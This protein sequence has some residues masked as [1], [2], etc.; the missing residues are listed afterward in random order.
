MANTPQQT[1]GIAQEFSYAYQGAGGQWVMTKEEFEGHKGFPVVRNGSIGTFWEIPLLIDETTRYTLSEW[2]FS[3]ECLLVP[4][5]CKLSHTP[6]NSV[7]FTH[8]L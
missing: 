1:T 6:I 7:S 3:K 8:T 4:S 5:S 2:S